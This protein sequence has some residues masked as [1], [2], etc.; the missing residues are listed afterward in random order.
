MDN[1]F[2]FYSSSCILLVV[3]YVAILMEILRKTI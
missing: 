3:N 2:Y 1:V